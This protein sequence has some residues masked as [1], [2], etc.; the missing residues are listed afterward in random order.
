M[1]INEAE[2]SAVQANE[3]TSLAPLRA[4]QHRD[5]FG[6][7]IA[8]PDKSNPTRSR[9][10]RPLDT[11]R[12]FE[13]AIDGPYPQRP[14]GGRAESEVDWS[15][16]RGSYYAPRNNGPSRPPSMYSNA[17]GSRY[18][19]DNHYGSRPTSHFESRN[20]PPARDSYHEAHQY[21]GSHGQYGGGQ[22][23]YG[24]TNGMPY[25]GR[26]RPMK[27][28]SEPHFNY[29]RREPNP[30]YPIQHRDRSYETV[31]SAAGSGASGDQGSYQTDPSSDN[32][33][34][35]RASPP[36][37]SPPLNDYGIGFGGPSSYQPHPFAVG[38]NNAPSPHQP[39]AFANAPGGP[40]SSYQQPSFSA[41]PNRQPA[42]IH[43]KPVPG[44]L[45]SNL[46]PTVPRKD[47]GPAQANLA[48]PKP[49]PEKRKSWLFRRFSK[50]S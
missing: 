41:G 50:A 11:I 6:N 5:A 15:S 47:I 26:Q 7:P 2:P 44:T 36:K 18:P 14:S 39:P 31:A 1:A 23:G 3:H 29:N 37:P 4:I 30:V 33:S 45:G 25:Q 48:P 19:T 43:K 32:S 10:E 38:D 34:F 46:P 24:P 8:E 28:P 22:G 17:N 20:T 40:A 9:W 13:A 21:G 12:S 49:A 42:T 27:M 35:D 16:R